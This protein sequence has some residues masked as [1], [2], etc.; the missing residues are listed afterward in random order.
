MNNKCRQKVFKLQYIFYVTLQ[1]NKGLSL[2][3]RLVRKGDFNM[4]WHEFI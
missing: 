2:A 3:L 4:Y 1:L